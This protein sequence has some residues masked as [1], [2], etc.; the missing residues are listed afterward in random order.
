MPRSIRR[1][2]VGGTLSAAGTISGNLYDFDLNGAAGGKNIAA[3]GN[4]IHQFTSRYAWTNART[5]TAT[6]A[7]AVDADSVMAGGFALDTVAARLSYQ[8]LRGT[9][10]G[11]GAAGRTPRLRVE[12]RLR[13]VHGAQRAS[14]RRPA[15]ATRHVAV[16]GAASGD[17]S[18]GRS[19]HR[20]RQSR[21]AQSRERPRV[22][23]RAA[24]DAG[25]GELRVGDRE[26]PGHQ[27]GGS[28]GERPSARGSRQPQRNDGGD[29]Q[30]SRVSRS[31]RDH[32]GRVSGNDASRA[33]RPLRVRQPRARHAHRRDPE[34]RPADGDGGR[35][36]PDQSRVQR[37]D[38]Q[39]P[40]RRADVGRSRRGQP[41]HR[42]DPALHRRGG[43]PARP[44]R[45]QHRHAR[46]SR[47]A[48]ADRG[49][50]HRQHQ[51]DDQGERDARRRACTA[52]CTWPTT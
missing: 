7:V 28:A 5:P 9:R 35:T 17:D 50:R 18:L 4:F 22:R 12:R 10:R 43:G 24:A 44:G 16:D 30:G 52:R 31:V 14:A 20:G 8:Q 45:R 3:R 46:P 49:A 48:V 41:A 27:R 39:P 13:A 36:H 6:L 11:P 40:D 42:A 47:S 25:H 32:A 34:R 33:P 19:G 38:R 51:H 1:D 2:T 15:D 37:R 29:P 21:A 23:Q 26:L